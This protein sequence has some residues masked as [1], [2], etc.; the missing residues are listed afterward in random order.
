MPHLSLKHSEADDP[1]LSVV[2]PLVFNLGS[3]SIKDRCGILKVKSAVGQSPDAFRWIVGDAHRIIVCTQMP[4]GKWDA[5][6][7]CL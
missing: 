6:E 4:L 7:G 3:Q 2:L 5:G 1:S